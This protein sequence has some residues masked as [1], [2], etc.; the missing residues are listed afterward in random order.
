MLWTGL[1][2]ERARK[3]R[4]GGHAKEEP[5]APEGRG[6]DCEIVKRCFDFTSVVFPRLGPLE[7]ESPGTVQGTEFVRCERICAL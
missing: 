1:I 5:E 7:N 3:K 6:E 4:K 2:F